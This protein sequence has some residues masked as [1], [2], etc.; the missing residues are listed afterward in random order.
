MSEKRDYYEVLGVQ[1]GASDDELKKAYKKL[2]RKY[3]PDLN[4]DDPKTAEEKFKEV[5]EAY[6]VLKD[7]QKR[8]QYDQFGHAAFE[9]G[10]GGGG[11]YGGFGG[12]GGGGFSGGDFGGFD[13]G[14]IF[15]DIFGG[16]GRRGARRQ[17][18][19]RGADLRY[20]LELT[21][22]EAAFGKETE[23]RVPRTENCEKCHGTGAAPGS[24]P[25]TCPKCHGSGQVQTVHNTPLGRMMS[26]STCDRCHGS[27][28]IVK[29]PCPDCGG[30]GQKRVERKI[31]VKIPAG[32]GEGSRI[33]VSGGGEAGL[34]GGQ[35]G[36]LYVYIFVKQHKFFTRNETDVYSEVPISFVQAAL[37]DTVQVPT[38]HGQ[39]ELKIPAGTQSGKQFRLRGKGIPKLRGDGNGDHYVKVKV[40]TPQKLTEKQKK[41]LQEFGELCGENVNPEQK[42]WKDS[43]KRFFGKE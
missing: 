29:N 26:S 38:L 39:I 25:E 5:N 35:S 23:L 9:G 28:K 30:R 42:S 8:A 31:K 7:P 16:G 2:A 41:L 36:D 19:E 1:K 24:E 10:A 14:D 20:D 4:R 37:G 17:G 33:R 3:H 22:E 40:L 27:G 43:V 13:F 15:G 6:D 21:F 18:P 34:R 11:G 32:V 12:F